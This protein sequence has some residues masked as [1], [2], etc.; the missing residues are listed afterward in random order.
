M[1]PAQ[2]QRMLTEYSGLQVRKTQLE[3]VIALEE[4]A[5]MIQ[6]SATTSTT[7]RDAT[8]TTTLVVSQASSVWTL[9]GSELT[10][11]TTRMTE[12]ETLCEGI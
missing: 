2:V 8:W 6:V 4:T 11:I 3:A 12:I 7:T 10:S 9:L 5:T 1:T